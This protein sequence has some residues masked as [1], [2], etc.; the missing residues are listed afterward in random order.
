MQFG[1]FALGL[2]RQP[3]L[4]QRQEIEIAAI[5]PERVEIGIAQ[6]APVDEFDPQLERAL[7]GLDEFVLVDPQRFVKVRIGGIVASPTPT[8]PISSLSISVIV[9]PVRIALASAAAVIQPAVPPP[10]IT[11]ERIEFSGCIVCS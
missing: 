10:T 7:A 1:R 2:R 5:G 3:V 4:V 9:Q 8:V 11:T 6:R